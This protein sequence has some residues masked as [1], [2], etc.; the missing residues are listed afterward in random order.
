MALR[1]CN[2]QVFCSVHEDTET[3]RTHALYEPKLLLESEML[4]LLLMARRTHSCREVNREVILINLCTILLSFELLSFCRYICLILK[5]A[6]FL[7]YPTCSQD[8]P[9]MSEYIHQEFKYFE[10]LSPC[11]SDTRCM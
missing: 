10:N 7:H 4:L 2:E 3:P 9:L 11:P 1:S 5:T 6:S 8:R